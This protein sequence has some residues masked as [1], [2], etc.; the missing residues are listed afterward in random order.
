MKNKRKLPI[1]LLATVTF[2]AAMWVGALPQSA[3]AA[4]ISLVNIANGTVYMGMQAPEG[5]RIPDTIELLKDTPY[6]ADPDDPK[7]K[8]EGVFA[9]QSVRVLKGEASWSISSGVQWQIDTMYGPRWVRPFMWDIAITKPDA[10]VLTEETR[11]YQS[12]NDQVEPVASLSPQ[13]VQVVN[14]EDKWFVGD[15]RI[16]KAWVQIHTT[17]LGDLWI[18]IPINKIGTVRPVLHRAHYNDEPYY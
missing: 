14:I 6:Y 10:I 17:W 3:K 15:S 9:P 11:L 2:A 13:E 1:A 5:L 8:A 16:G 4:E 7:E 18:H 12:R